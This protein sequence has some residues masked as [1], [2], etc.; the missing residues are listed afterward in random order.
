MLLLLALCIR[1]LLLPLRWRA[2]YS[3]TNRGLNPPYTA[4]IHN[5][6]GR[7]GRRC[8]LTDLLDFSRW[9]R[10]ARVSGERRL[11]ALEGNGGRRRSGSRHHGTAQHRGRRARSAR[12]RIRPGA[13]NTVPLRCDGR[14]GH[15]L[16]R[17]QL[18]GRY[19]ARV[20]SHAAATGEAVLGNCR[21]RVLDPPVHIVNPRIIGIPATV[22]IV[23]RGVV[24]HRVGVVHAGK[25]T[26]ARLVRRKIRL[27]RP[28]RKPAYRRGSADAE[29]QAETQPA[30]SSADP[31]HQSRSIQRSHAIRSRYPAPAPAKGSPTAVVIGS[32]APRGV[33]HPGPTPG[34][35]PGPMAVM[36][37]R[38]AC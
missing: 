4:H 15:H 33:V 16:Y 9:Q 28:Q 19:E 12:R 3:P 22:I 1:L 37:R 18:S 6:N 36:I 14:S 20:L 31:A 2:L 23:D 26:L 29:T 35:D 17:S 38:P 34:R 5:A 25:V 13:E 10:A 30:A 21:H 8:T 11:L 32:K 7:A 27:A 24:E